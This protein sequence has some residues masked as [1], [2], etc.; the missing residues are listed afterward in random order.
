MSFDSVRQVSA[1]STALILL[2]GLVEPAAAT[3]PP[4]PEPPRLRTAQMRAT[5]KLVQA[6]DGTVEKTTPVCETSGTI[7]VYSG[8]GEGPAARHGQIYGCTLTWK[9]KKLDVWVAG[10]LSVAGETA[11]WASAS[12]SVTPPDAKPGCPDICGP[13]PL[14]EAR[15]DVKVN[16]AAKSVTFSLAPNPVSILRSNPSV[17]FEATV[18]ITD[19]K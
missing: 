11:T 18:T 3:P 8:S 13:Q 16:N 2:F 19:S 6:K 4:P 14:A 12:V 1:T 17:W 7:P 10:A 5:V 15:A 9:G